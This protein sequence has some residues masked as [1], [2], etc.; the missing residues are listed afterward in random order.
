MK[1]AMVGD[2]IHYFTNFLPGVFPALTTLHLH[3]HSGGDEQCIVLRMLAERVVTPTRLKSITI[4][5]RL[6]HNSLPAMCKYCKT[7]VGSLSAEET[8]TSWKNLLRERFC[9]LE[10]LCFE[11]QKQDVVN[12]ATRIDSTLPNLR[13]VLRFRYRGWDEDTSMYKYLRY[14]VPQPL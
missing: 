1:L 3:I 13:S 14:V 12:C 7:M 10:E 8:T 9:S 2:R 11:M 4:S 6:L 5:S